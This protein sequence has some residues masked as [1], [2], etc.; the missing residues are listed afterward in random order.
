MD[1]VCGDAAEDDGED[2]CDDGDSDGDDGDDGDDDAPTF[3]NQSVLSAGMLLPGLLLT[4]QLLCPTCTG[5]ATRLRSAGIS[6][7]RS[8]GSSE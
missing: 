7:K 6:E 2:A 8:P 4:T 1:C 3:H 5:V